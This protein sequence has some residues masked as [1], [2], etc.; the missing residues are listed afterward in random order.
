MEK[1]L[2]LIEWSDKWQSKFN[3][4]K[5]KVLYIGPT[6]TRSYSVLDL[7]DHKH[8]E[9]EFIEKGE[10][11]GIIFDNNLKFFSHTINHV[12]KAN[13]LM[14]PIRR[15][16]T[17]L[18]KNSFRYLLNEL[19]RPHLEYCVSIWYP[20]LKKDAELIENVLRRASE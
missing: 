17:Y 2:Y 20:L 16:Y 13:Q 4:S 3:T 19:V 1:K 11:L 5:C 6:N 15:S 14:G 9:L 10:E 12:N 18:D 8:K 7:K